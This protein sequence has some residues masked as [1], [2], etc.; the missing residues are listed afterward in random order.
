MS[1][2]NES[3]RSEGSLRLAL[4]LDILTYGIKLDEYDKNLF[5]EY[6]K[7]PVSDT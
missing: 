2:R 1:I 6:I 4:L 5:I 7:A 3:G